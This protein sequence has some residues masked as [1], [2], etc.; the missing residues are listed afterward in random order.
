MSLLRGEKTIPQVVACLFMLAFT[1]WVLAQSGISIEGTFTADGQS[2]AFDFSLPTDVTSADTLYF[3][4]WS[5]SGGTNLAGDVIPAGGFDPSLTLINSIPTVVGQVDDG[6][7]ISGNFDSLLDFNTTYANTNPPGIALPDPLPAGDYRLVLN[8]RSNTLSGRNPNWAI[9]LVA[10]KLSLDFNADTNI[11][12][13]A[14]SPGMSK[15]TVQGSDADWNNTGNIRVANYGVGTLN[16]LDGGDVS[17][18][19]GYIAYN[20]NSVGIATVSGAGSSWRHTDRFF[21]GLFGHGTLNIENGGAVNN[22][23]V[24][25][26]AAGPDSTGIAT[27]S[28]A[29]SVWV[30][31]NNLEV[32]ST[33][34]GTLNVLDG[35]LV[36]NTSGTIGLRTE[37]TGVATVSGA[38]SLWD[39]SN[40]L[41]VGYS[42]PGTL[43]IED[44]GRVNSKYGRISGITGSTGVAT[45]TGA[46]SKWVSTDE[47]SVGF[48]NVGTLNI[49]DG[50]SASGGR[51]TIGL[52]TGSM[53][54]ATVNGA[55]STLTYSSSLTVGGAGNGALNIQAGGTVG[56]STGTIGAHLAS[57]G[58]TTVTGANSTW[59]ITDTLNVGL[60]ATGTLD[61]ENGGQVTSVYGRISAFPGSTGTVTVTDPGSTWTNRVSLFVGGGPN[62]VGGSGRLNIN[63]GGAMTVAD[64]LK[65]WNTGTVSLTGGTLDTQSLDI[66]AG[67]TLSHIGGTLTVAGG[68]M[69]DGN[70]GEYKIDGAGAPNL[71]LNNA[72]FELG[73]RQLRVGE[74]QNGTLTVEAGG[75]VSNNS[76]LI[77]WGSIST[78]VATVTGSGSQWNH[79]SDL[80]VGF[81]GHGT[82]N[83]EAGGVVS[84]NSGLIGFSPISTG[85]ATVT[86]SGS[87]WNNSIGLSVGVFGHG[88]LTV[89]AGGVVRN[90]IGYIGFELGSTGVATVTGAASQ[91]NNSNN[92]YVGGVV[93]AAGGDGTLD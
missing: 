25:E 56:S 51:G 79:S 40:F 72:L 39:N 12:P 36:R 30:N 88:T 38:D 9:D 86:G 55:N 73:T 31:D 75:V 80:V 47:L 61:I 54:T 74:F 17:D 50:G 34:H 64:T 87:Q 16:I 42:G 6:T 44:G 89:E 65:I 48:S 58:V 46:N 4:T 29:S 37:S 52:S 41:S 62:E 59:D 15:V 32:G 53:G 57:I 84:N 2:Q 91:W 43:T 71:V 1:P 19:L 5:H 35:G 67:G 78:G 70:T 21:I 10:P 83:V 7:G 81:S 63:N 22:T 11:G 68:S 90:R 60:E 92:L 27:V 26:I 3:R 93:S 14:G 82:L 8:Q 20:N 18:A 69:A 28:G 33:G 23:G 13:L 66:V 76:G 24:A 85:V 45:I 49:F 77:G